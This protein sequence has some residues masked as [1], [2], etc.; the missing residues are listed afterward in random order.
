MTFQLSPPVVIG[1]ADDGV[2][3]SDVW[4]LPRTCDVC[5]L[6]IL[7]GK[8]RWECNV[9]EGE[10]GGDGY[11][12]CGQCYDSAAMGGGGGAKGGKGGKGKGKKKRKREVGFGHEHG[13]KAF[14]LAE[15]DDEDS[16]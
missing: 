2:D 14:S 5:M 7:P 12:L 13:L 8:K 16:D 10:G 6:Y 1:F 4:E 9:C 3:R 11:D 15:K